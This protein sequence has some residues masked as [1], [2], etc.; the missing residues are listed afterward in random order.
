MMARLGGCGCLFMLSLSFLAGCI[1][2]LSMLQQVYGRSMCSILDQRS[3]SNPKAV[4]I[5]PVTD[6]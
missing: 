5:G 3:M 1:F 6:C 4:W 2:V